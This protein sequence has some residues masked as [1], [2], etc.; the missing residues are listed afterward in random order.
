ML[1]TYV[2]SEPQPGDIEQIVYRNGTALSW[3]TDW[4]FINDGD[5][6][7]LTNVYPDTDKPMKR[8][9]K[10][11]V[12]PGV[13]DIFTVSYY[14]DISNTFNIP[15]DTSGQYTVDMVGDQSARL[16]GSNTIAFSSTRK[17]VEVSY[18]DLYLLILLRRN[19]AESYLSPAIEEY[20]LVTGSID[21]TKFE[22][23]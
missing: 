14:P 10:L 19:S 5:S 11:L 23:E 16:V 22:G 8:G 6:S 20:M 2:P 3:G 1:Y 15:T 4:E 21:Q 17:G 18:T 7:G 12:V 9:I 13:L